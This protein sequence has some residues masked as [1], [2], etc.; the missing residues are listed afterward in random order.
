[1]EDIEHSIAE[2]GFLTNSYPP[3]LDGTFETLYSSKEQLRIFLESKPSRKRLHSSSVRDL[4]DEPQLTCPSQ[5]HY[6]SA[7]NI[8]DFY[9][10]N[11]QNQGEIDE[12]D[13]EQE[14]PLDQQ[15]FNIS[16]RTGD[17]VEKKKSFWQTSVKIPRWLI[18]CSCVFVLLILTAVLLGFLL[19]RGA[20]KDVSPCGPP[21][22]ESWIWV[23]GR[24]YF[25]SNHYK[26]WNDSLEFCNTH[27]SALA[28][29]I[30][31]EIQKNIKRYRETV[32]YWIGLS[33]NQ[34]GRWMWTNGSPYNGS[35]DNQN[36]S[37]LRCAYLN[38]HLGALDCS[39]R[40]Q[41]I[42]VKDSAR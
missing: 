3:T 10:S 33:M 4:D 35:V 39:T 37:D 8:Q 40:R 1:M 7:P 6:P 32:N 15:S 29:L 13:K 17:N 27:G 12:A 25:F 34:D 9:R 31:P 16:G 2:S 21:C 23:G 24:C 30:N 41:W 26:S 20:V 36:I 28:V 22:E 42:C 11:Y 14:T 38:S 5:M 19:S 18:A